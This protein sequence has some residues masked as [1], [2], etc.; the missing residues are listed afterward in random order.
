MRWTAHHR[1][2]IEDDT[3][4]RTEGSGCARQVAEDD[5]SLPSHLLGLERHHVDDPAIGGEEREQLLPQLLFLD[6]VVEVFDVQRR[7]RLGG[8]HGGRWRGRTHA[9]ASA[10]CGLSGE[11]TRSHDWYVLDLGIILSLEHV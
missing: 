11:F 2:I 7:V 5:E 6:L 8:G 10:K 9:A 3:F 4:A 1:F